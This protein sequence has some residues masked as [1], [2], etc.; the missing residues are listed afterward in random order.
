MEARFGWAIDFIANRPVPYRFG[1]NEL[2]PELITKVRA[3]AEAKL[4]TSLRL[5]EPGSSRMGG[6]PRPR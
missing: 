4:G 5:R 2:A 1:S 3:A 6:A